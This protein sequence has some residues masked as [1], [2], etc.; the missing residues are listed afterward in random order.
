MS[1]FHYYVYDHKSYDLTD[2][3]HEKKWQS[4]Q[5]RVISL[6]KLICTNSRGT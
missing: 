6:E 5:E 3:E 1:W 4:R 2:K